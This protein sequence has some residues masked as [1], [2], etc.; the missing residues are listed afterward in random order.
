VAAAARADDPEKLDRGG[1]A[2]E[3]ARALLLGDKSPATCRWTFKVTSTDPGSAAASTRAATFGASPNTSPVASMTTWP[4]SIPMRALSSGAPLAAFLALSSAS[5]LWI[6][7]AART[8]RSASFSCARGY[9]KTAIIPSPSI[10]TTWPPSPITAFEAS[11][12]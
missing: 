12:R 9:P 2:L 3:F 7:S 10:L 1:H 6:A 11:L 8:A 5:A 4:D